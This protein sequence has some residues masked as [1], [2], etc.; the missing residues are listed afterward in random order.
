VSFEQN[1]TLKQFVSFS[2]L[3]SS[4]LLS[5]FFE[6]WVCFRVNILA[7][8][9]IGRYDN[10]PR[11]TV[12]EEYLGE[13]VW[14][15]ECKGLYGGR[16]DRRGFCFLLFWMFCV[17]WIIASSNVVIVGI[18]FLALEE[19]SFPSIPRRPHPPRAPP[20]CRHPETIR[21]CQRP[22]CQRAPWTPSWRSWD[23]HGSQP[24]TAWSA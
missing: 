15:C 21:A 2:H 6:F 8:V 17:W 24:R 23:Q 3:P 14:V 12:T 19:I 11:I 10:P 22:W 18:V 5:A 7:T 13:E 9:I 16:G 4:F 1:N 20:S